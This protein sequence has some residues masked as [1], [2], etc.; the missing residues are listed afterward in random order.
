MTANKYKAVDLQQLPAQSFEWGATKWLV[1]PGVTPGAN[2]SFGEVALLPGMGHDRHNHP[3]SEE[4]LYVLSGEGLQ[5]VGDEDPFPVRAGDTIY[6]PLG[7]FHSTM[8]TGWA[9]LRLLAIYNPGGPERDL[10]G[11]PDF[12]EVAAGEAPGWTR[13]S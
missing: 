4:I 9:P 11:L 2:M 6:V 13:S 7:V 12:R 1:A 5:M 10:E 8:N 3:A